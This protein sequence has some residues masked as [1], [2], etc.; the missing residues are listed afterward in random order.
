[1]VVPKDTDFDLLAVIGDLCIRFGNKI[2]HLNNYHRRKFKSILR[3]HTIQCYKSSKWSIVLYF[4]HD[5]IQIE[6]QHLH[7]LLTLTP[8]HSINHYIL[9]FICL[10]A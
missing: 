5:R 3:D 7:E 4:R 2:S 9:E 8:K 10:Y 6:K 1:M